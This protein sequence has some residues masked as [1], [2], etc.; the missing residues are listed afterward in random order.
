[1]GLL[2]LHPP[3]AGDHHDYMALKGKT[4]E[5][6][7]NY[8]MKVI[9]ELKPRNPANALKDCI[10]AMTFAEKQHS[11]DLNNAIR[12]WLKLQ[13]SHFEMTENIGT[14]VHIISSIIARAGDGLLSKAV[15]TGKRKFL[16]D[17]YS[18]AELEESIRQIEVQAQAGGL[19]VCSDCWLLCEHCSPPRPY[20]NAKYWE[21]VSEEHMQVLLGDRVE[22]RLCTV[23]DMISCSGKY[24]QLVLE[25]LD[26]LESD[27]VVA[28]RHMRP[29]AA[30]IQTINL[31]SMQSDLYSS[32]NK[33]MREGLEAG[34]EQFRPF[35]YHT[36]QA[37]RHLA[38]YHGSTFRGIDCHVPEELYVV[39]SVVT[40]QAF[41]SSSKN[42]AI[43]SLFLSGKDDAPGTLFVLFSKTGRLIK[44]F[45]MHTEEDEVLHDYNSQWR[46]HRK[47][48]KDKALLAAAMKRNL[49]LVDVYVLVEVNL[50]TWGDVPDE[51]THN[52]RVLNR[53]LLEFIDM[54]PHTWKAMD[55]ALGMYPPLINSLPSMEFEGGTTT[56]LHLLA[57]QPQPVSAL[58]ICSVNLD[59]SLIDT[60]DSEGRTPLAVAVQHCNIPCALG[61]LHRG[62]SLDN[63]PDDD[64]HVLLLHWACEEGDQAATILILTTSRVPGIS[65]YWSPKQKERPLTAA[66]RNGHVQLCALLVA[67]GVSLDARHE[68]DGTTALW[69]A[70]YFGHQ[71]VV[72]LL[73]SKGAD[74]RVLSSTGES[75][76]YAAAQKGRTP[77]VQMLIKE[78]GLSANEAGIGNNT[79]LMAAAHQ[80]HWNL[81]QY[82]CEAAA[83]VNATNQIGWSPLFM[84]S[85]MG[86]TPV[87]KF[88][89]DKGA[90]PNSTNHQG[91]APL[92][93]ASLNG[94]AETIT[95]LLDSGANI[96]HTSLIGTTA[97]HMASREGQVL[98]V[99]A[100][101]GRGANVNAQDNFGM[102]PVMGAAQCGLCSI[103]IDLVDAGADL[104]LKTKTGMTAFL[105]ACVQGMADGAELLLE[106][107]AT[108][109]CVSPLPA[110]APP[111]NLAA[112]VGQ[113]KLVQVMLRRGADIN[114]VDAHGW[115]ALMIALARGNVPTCRALLEKG[116][117]LAVQDPMG[118]SP[119]FCAALAG[120]LEGV[121]MLVDKKADLSVATM[122]G[123]RA[124]HAASVAGHQPVVEFLQ[125]SGADIFAANFNG[126]TPW[127]AA[128]LGDKAGLGQG[129]A[130]VAKYFERQGVRLNQSYCDRPASILACPDMMQTVL[131]HY[132]GLFD[133]FSGMWWGKDE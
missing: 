106:K 91:T 52:E 126:I 43:A 41:T 89:L 21:H 18:C 121:Q 82:L 11:G 90:D 105:M 57:R 14:D 122:Y 4:V 61:F 120:C 15:H 119:L 133:R 84:A 73:A 35:I 5:H 17:D 7:L 45:S 50:R 129:C 72:S 68:I 6:Y 40:W 66:A 10:A 31:Y 86:H 63:I 99:K 113:P 59:P 19:P 38:V 2:T 103:M 87:V 118:W 30:Q 109:T 3:T 131:N 27:G 12:E 36:H 67:H 54:L 110:G 96:N 111:L 1:L 115:T 77:V 37:L 100:L 47:M 80:G 76:L 55:G 22:P 79:P 48:D 26:G 85:Q 34:I 117:S 94:F 32:C 95:V 16:T 64:D 130:D 53:D 83:D 23:E 44:P 70:A 29:E 42:P 9:L 46:V 75:V 127:M 123:E 60:K 8:M 116:A 81:V 20:W 93:M 112:W 92:L 49:E 125:S 58:R 101:I 13:D 107:G 69:K 88:L 62:A 25:K 24:A 98:A 114:A 104:E 78:H 56:P 71:P 97:L 108:H 28:E 102:T 74:I 128:T 33:A 39:D 132:Q 51:L 124:V 65:T